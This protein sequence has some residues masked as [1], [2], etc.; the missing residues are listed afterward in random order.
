[1]EQT[2]VWKYYKTAEKNRQLKQAEIV[3]AQEDNFAHVQQLKHEI[4]GLLMVEE[5]L[6]HQRSQSHWIKSDDR[7][8]SY[9]HSKAS[10][11]F[12]RNSIHGLQ[13]SNGEMCIGDENVAALLVEY[14]TG[15]FSTR[16][17]CEIDS[18]LQIVPRIVIDEMN[19]L[20][21]HEFTRAEVDIAL[22]QMGL[23]KAP[24]SDGMPPIF[25]SNIIGM[26]LEA[27]LLLQFSHALNALIWPKFQQV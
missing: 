13:N 20:L 18:I 7:N 12:R 2:K 23:L 25:F 17:P 14:Y 8:T 15:L 9:F 4:N 11:R 6:W 5:K 1:M 16:N 22:S 10:H 26:I 24:S 21:G 19:T 3:A 27:M